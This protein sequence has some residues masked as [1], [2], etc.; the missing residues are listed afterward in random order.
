MIKKFSQV[1]ER[2]S[3]RAWGLVHGAAGGQALSE[4]GVIVGVVVG[5]LVVAAVVAFRDEIVTS[6]KTATSAL[7]NAR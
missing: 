7:R 4:Y 3:L 5:I 2:L 1:N 6:F